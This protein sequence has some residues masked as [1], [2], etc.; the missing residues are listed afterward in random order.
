MDRLRTD[1]SMTRGHEM[2]IDHEFGI[3]RERLVPVELQML[4]N[5][6]PP[7]LL[8]VEW[9]EMDGM[10]SFRY[11]L[12]GRKML[13]HRLQ[14]QP[15]SMQQFYTLLLAVVE[16]LDE[17]KHYMLRPEGCLLS[18]RF[19]FVGEQLTDIRLA[20]MPLRDNTG[21][22]RDYGSL[23]TL[24]AG[25]SAYVS[26][27]DG[28]GLQL[29]LQLANEREYPCQELRVLLLR[30]IGEGGQADVHEL[31]G[32][33]NPQANRSGGV[34]ADNNPDYDANGQLQSAKTRLNRLSGLPLDV[35]ANKVRNERFPSN[36]SDRWNGEPGWNASSSLSGNEKEKAEAVLN[37]RQSSSRTPQEW[38]NSSMS[39]VSETGS[40]SWG[41]EALGQE[42]ANESESHW[43]E[44][45]PY[46]GSYAEQSAEGQAIDG[47][48]AADSRGKWIKSALITLAAA[49][50]W[51][52]LYLA[53][54]G[55]SSLYIC[56]G[57]SMM[58]LAG[59]L[60][61]W[62]KKPKGIA[63][64]SWN[65]AVDE[66]EFNPVSQLLDKRKRW[67]QAGPARKEEGRSSATIKKTDFLYQGGGR[68]DA[69]EEAGFPSINE[70]RTS[71]S[72]CVSEGYPAAASFPARPYE[73]AAST[74]GPELGSSLSQ[75]SSH[76]SVDRNSSL[77]VQGGRYFPDSP[78]MTGHAAHERSWPD[79]GIDGSDAGEDGHIR[80]SEEATVMLGGP[81]SSGESVM[82]ELFLYREWQ[83][84]E[85]RLPWNGEHYLVGRAE[86]Q[87]SYTEPAAGVSRLH[88]EI[89]PL[90]GGKFQVKDLGSR[91]GSL[92]NGAAMI[93]YKM[94]PVSEGDI[95]QLAGTDGPRYAF[96]RT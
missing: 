52:Y 39:V 70:Y 64:E 71:G 9:F 32:H 88:L 35:S 45:D 73:G 80:I 42:K 92:L 40:H 69:A 55:K 63:M 48:A 65:A 31:K 2:I 4:Q 58:G 86:D 44:E 60:F 13:S 62:L 16:A 66:E 19:L 14:L 29:I 90:N 82:G 61:I 47:V 54:P 22:E 27:I 95:L 3:A 46:E 11:A 59:L 5:S 57:L 67:G 83:G 17:C 56:L 81:E 37:V 10:V 87:V 12:N 8:P 28:T 49:L 68:L 84:K 41:Y 18:D 72:S 21:L 51:R 93:P 89:E 96:K 26:S 7:R 15:V 20:Y 75:G 94:Y 33:R 76:I 53:S 85:Q 79:A 50:S 24:I 74:G 38:P 25:L 6:R 91:N 30:L 23:L 36:S 34:T 77:P 78:S 1:F 43:S